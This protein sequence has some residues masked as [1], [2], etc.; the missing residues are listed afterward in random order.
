MY[1]QGDSKVSSLTLLL[2]LQLY[3]VELFEMFFDEEVIQNIT[4]IEEIIMYADQKGST[5]A[6]CTA[7]E[8][9][10]FTGILLL[11]GYV[12]LPYRRIY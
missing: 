9:K 5:I 10:V 6:E 12:E 4:C 1:Y 8:I 3:L 11:S 7:E 2:M